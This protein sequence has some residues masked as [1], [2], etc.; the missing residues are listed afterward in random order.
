[1]RQNIRVLVA[2]LVTEIARRIFSWQYKFSPTHDLSF[3]FGVIVDLGIWISG[4][5][6][7]YWVYGRFVK[8]G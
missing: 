7:T 1:M 5:W 4:F 2:F 3:G 6:F 8:K